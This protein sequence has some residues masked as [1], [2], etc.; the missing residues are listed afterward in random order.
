M[1][2][3]AKSQKSALTMLNFLGDPNSEL[4][5]ALDLELTHPGPISVLGPGRCKRFAMH[6]VDGVIEAVNVSETEDDPTGE[7]DHSNSLADGIMATMK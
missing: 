3:W 1:M 7:N 2:N 4:T 5:R 6:V